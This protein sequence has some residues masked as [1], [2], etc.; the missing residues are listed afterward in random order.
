MREGLCLRVLGCGCSSQC[1]I[2]LISML[3]DVAAVACGAGRVVDS[4]CWVLTWNIFE[5]LLILYV[6]SPLVVSVA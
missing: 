3:R 2:I 4:C 6:W 1:A 5:F